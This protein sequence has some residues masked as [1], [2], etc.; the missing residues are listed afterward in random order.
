M[1]T[2]QLFFQSGQAKDLSA[3]LYVCTHIIQKDARF[4]HVMAVTKLRGVQHIALFGVLTAV[5]LK[6]KAHWNVILHHRVSSPR[7]SKVL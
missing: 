1:A 4:M 2:Y 3:P 6:N 7:V 5:L